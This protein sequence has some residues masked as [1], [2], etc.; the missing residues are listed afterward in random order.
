MTARHSRQSF[1]GPNSDEAI[2]SAIVGVVG[3]GGG[4]AH[5]VQ[6]LAHVGFRNYVLYD[7]DSIEI[8]NLNRLVG[9]TMIDGLA[10]TP[11][12]QVAQR[13]IYGLQP[14]AE[15][16]AYSCRWQEQPEPLRACQI[17]FGCIETYM[18]RAELE[19]MCRRYLIH[20]LDIGMDV[21]GSNPPVI[22]GQVIQSSPTGPCMKCMGFLTDEK[23]AM[24]AR[25]YGNAGGRPQVVWPNGQLASAAVGLAVDLVTGWT[26]R[27]RNH[28]Y[29]VLDGNEGTLKE[30]LTLRH[31]S[32]QCGHFASQDIGD[33]VAIEL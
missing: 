20:Y 22:G 32:R 2:A 30:S 10:R 8:S 23:L 5:I 4:G 11:K 17:L 6:Q 12:I 21:H 31:P 28:A 7:D 16:E 27:Q 14:D 1:L 15:I 18:G 3:L 9:A 24:E 26:H 25:E 13:I 19:I 29:L 33:P